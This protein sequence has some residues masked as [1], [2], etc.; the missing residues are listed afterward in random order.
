MLQIYAPT[1]EACEEEKEDFYKQLQHEIEKTPNNDILLLMGNVKAKV[2]RQMSNGKV[3][4]EL[5]E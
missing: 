5:K 2:G 1:N 4:F 3:K